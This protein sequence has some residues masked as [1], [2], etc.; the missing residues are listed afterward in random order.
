M[1]LV[2]GTDKRRLEW[3]YRSVGHNV[4]VLA[5]VR[6]DQGKGVE[7]Y[8]LSATVLFDQDVDGYRRRNCVMS[9]MNNRIQSPIQNH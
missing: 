6:G 3:D 8:A 5:D 1:G 4:N 2:L 9:V 7:D